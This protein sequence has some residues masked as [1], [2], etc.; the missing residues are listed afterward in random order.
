MIQ[1]RS[2]PATAK[3]SMS[4]AARRKIA[5]ATEKMVVGESEEARLNDNA[6]TKVIPDHTSSNAVS[7]A[8]VR[9]VSADHCTVTSRTAACMH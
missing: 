7:G 8:C 2:K 5:A 3:R 4:P 1:S 6:A 9:R